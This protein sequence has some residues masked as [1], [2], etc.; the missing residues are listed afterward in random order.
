MTLLAKRYR[1][2]SDI[3]GSVAKTGLAFSIAIF[4]PSVSSINQLQISPMP[5][6]VGEADSRSPGLV[7]TII[8]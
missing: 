5:D 4:T 1:L 2:P 8:M 6:P 3:P 7:L